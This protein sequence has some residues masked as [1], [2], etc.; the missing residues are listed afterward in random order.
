MSAQPLSSARD[1]STNGATRRSIARRLIL[2]IV[3]FSSA[4]TLLATAYQLYRNY[5]ADVGHI[6][7]RLQQIRD[8]NLPVVANSLWVADVGELRIELDG[9][10][11]LPDMQYLEVSDETR[12]WVAVGEKR[13]SNVLRNEYPLVHLHRG[14]TLTIG[15]LSVIVNLEGVYQRLLE[16]ALVILVSNAVKTFLVAGFVFLLF[17]RL[18]T[19]HL[20][21][22]AQFLRNHDV[23]DPH[24]VLALERQRRDD[25][26]RDELDLVVDEFA[27][28]QANLVSAFAELRRNE[29]MLRTVIDSTPDWIF[30]KDRDHRFVLV[31]QAFADAQGQRPAD[32]IGRPDTDFLLAT[33]PGDPVA[34]RRRF[35]D[36]DDQAMSGRLVHM[37]HNTAF[38]ADRSQRFLDTLKVPLRDAEG[39][40]YGA[41]GYG[42][43]ITE[44]VAA[45][46][47][48]AATIARLEQ[49]E[50]SQKEA[51][52]L[53][54]REQGRLSA[55]LSA[56]GIGILFEDRN[57][58]IEYMNPSFLRIWGIEP[59]T[60]LTGRPTQEVLERSTHRFARP[61]RVSRY[62]LSVIDANEASERFEVELQ[63]GRI[64]TQVSY[65]VADSEG[66]LLGRLWI[67]E[68]I[69]HERQTAQQLI[70]LAE[71]DPLTGLFNRHYFQQHLEERL[72]QAQRTG[73]R[74]ALLYF[75]IDEFKGIND[76]FGHR[77]GDAVLVRAAGEVG[78]LVRGSELLARVGGD[79]FVVLGDVHSPEDVA[80]LAKRVVDTISA[81]PFRFKGTNMRVTTSVGAAVFPD[82][83]VTA[84]DLVVHS[85]AAMYLAKSRG[86]NTWALYHPDAETTDAMSRRHTWSQRIGQ[87]LEQGLLELYL[88]GIHDIATG[89]L[90]H[91]EAL[92]RMHDPAA[93][94]RVVMPG[95]F[96]PFAER[97]GQIIEI[98]RWVLE[99]AVT[100]LAE[101]P[102]MPPIA[103]NVSGRSFDEPSLPQ[104]V[105]G[106]LA[107]KGVAPERLMVEITETAT[108]SDIRDSQRFIEAIRSLGCG[109][110]L[111]DFG[112]G[113]SSFLY[114][115][116][117]DV[118]VLKI[119]GLFIRELAHNHDNQ[120][121]VRAMVDIA[122]GL[123]MRTVAEF[124]ENETILDTVRSLGV[125]LAQ[126]FHL[127]RPAAAA[128]AIAAAAEKARQQ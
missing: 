10:L 85:D 31:N 67:Y 27:S 119:D 89:A 47:E 18:V 71:R 24:A 44:R 68:D 57:G 105:R 2:Y 79:E 86:K 106:L 128:V 84:D 97:S 23:E 11:R 69:T 94:E 5:D 65:P 113:F 37:P 20:E 101:H 81:I 73:G 45:E 107:D 33:P 96:I 103:V 53:A 54:Q 91:F 19:R 75:D 25:G 116:Y 34:T 56:M 127:H 99:A 29:A 1:T 42:R 26:V 4:I 55:L 40:I 98:D 17:Q 70:Y 108:V 114:L 121:F 8:A 15:S 109:V 87:A 21:H 111:D 6:A 46:Q 95:Q 9:L 63:D 124:V 52:A 58:C 38:V 80:A 62:V 16:T 60:P 102:L 78:Q 35:H 88:Q 41:L 28:M 48:L 110:C 12:L 49:T 64:L 90:S 51:L 32:M 50:R 92:V 3:L 93:P 123:G 117:I 74:L 7:A 125:D 39:A 14:Q 43:D 112:T 61:D 126:G 83:A 100:L 22:I 59:R 72:R 82:H 122:R 36:S 120:L 118:D 13:N 115:K 76:T 30:A 66:R 77:T 104:H